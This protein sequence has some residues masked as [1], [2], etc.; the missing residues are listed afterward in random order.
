VYNRKWAVDKIM[1]SPKFAIVYADEDG[2][3]LEGV[4]NNVGFVYDEE[5]VEEIVRLH[6]F[7][8]DF[9]RLFSN[10]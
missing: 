3:P 4:M 9:T 1:Y 8:V 6:D 7:T 10:A 5:I 2:K